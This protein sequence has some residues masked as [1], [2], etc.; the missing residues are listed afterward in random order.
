MEQLRITSIKIGH[1][2]GRVRLSIGMNGASEP[3]RE[4]VFSV[5]PKQALRIGAKLIDACVAAKKFSGEPN[6]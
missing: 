1:Q 2:E 3:N 4:L 6:E 5:S